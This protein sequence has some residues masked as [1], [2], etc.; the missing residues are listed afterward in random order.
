[1]LRLWCLAGVVAAVLPSASG[2]YF[3]IKEGEVRC[4]TPHVYPIACVAMSFVA[5]HLT[6]LVQ[7]CVASVAGRAV[8]EFGWRLLRRC[9]PARA[10]GSGSFLCLAFSW[11]FS[12]ATEHV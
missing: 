8:A 12:H 9:V 3:H 4:S 10:L 11:Y 7:S 2:L 6:S 1:M 5:L